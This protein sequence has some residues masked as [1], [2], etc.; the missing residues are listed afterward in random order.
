M[1]TEG[2]ETAVPRPQHGLTGLTDLPADFVNTTEP[3]AAPVRT[4]AE[5][6]VHLD[7]VVESLS[8]AVL[9]DLTAGLAALADI[10]P[11]RIPV[12]VLAG[13]VIVKVTILGP[14]LDLGDIIAAELVTA[15]EDGAM[16]KSIPSVQYGSM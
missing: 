16:Q 10:D 4:H 12:D 11:D 9:S 15:F 13:S 5:L 1:S 14:D 7:M 2:S 3:T 8:P 6:L